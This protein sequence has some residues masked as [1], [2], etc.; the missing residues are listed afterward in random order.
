MVSKI[1]NGEVERA[2]S[3]T[4]DQ[5]IQQYEAYVSGEYVPSPNS[6]IMEQSRASSVGPRP[7][8]QIE[9]LY[10]NTA[11]L[12][13][14][15]HTDKIKVQISVVS[16]PH[17]YKRIQ[18]NG[19]ITPY[20]VDSFVKESMTYT[21]SN[22]LQN[23]FTSGS[24]VEFKVSSKEYV[25][26]GNHEDL[27]AI[28]ELSN[29]DIAA[30]LALEE[31]NYYLGTLFKT[32]ESVS[33]FCE[34]VPSIFDKFD[35]FA[36]VFNGFKSMVGYVS[37]KISNFKNKIAGQSF[38]QLVSV[39]QNYVQKIFTE[40][41]ERLKRFKLD[42]L[43]SAKTIRP[44]IANHFTKLKDDVESFFTEENMDSIKGTI[45]AQIQYVLDFFK[46]PDIEEI[47][48]IIYRFCSLLTT[49]KNLFNMKIEPL[50][51]AVQA[52]DETNLA[53]QTAS[54]K[55]TAGALRAGAIR[56]EPQ[57]Y[58]TVK[59]EQ[60]NYV[61]SRS[62][63]K[64]GNYN[65]QLIEITPMDDEGVT[66]WNNGKGDSRIG[67]NGQWVSKLGV[68]GW[69]GVKP[70]VRRMIMQVQ[71]AFGKRLI[72]NSGYRP[73]WYNDTIANSAKNSLHISGIALD[74]RWEGFNQSTAHGEFKNICKQVG[75]TG[76][77]K[78]GK[79]NSFIH[80]D[81]GNREFS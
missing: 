5:L 40:Q 65:P 61:K 6:N 4:A 25:E 37:E 8:S 34:M 55:A 1:L 33:S 19:F 39:V 17:V 70:Q 69:H 62:H 30:K 20:E 80:I 31:F 3:N 49:L 50:K 10:E 18:K 58:D 42:V 81:L 59:T 41:M 44:R 73:R 78:R 36:H 35:R 75:F 23:V 60:Y 66:P 72:I 43:S 57:Q 76:F 51:K 15:I 7:S 29:D 22:F 9:L 68:E 12:N 71:A 48:Y 67:F 38:N 11:I 56:F 47:Q 54:N 79:Y 16:Y 13:K 53:L 77:S 27:T 64:S 26:Q 14:F 28:L 46:D 32:D 21:H 74:V 2:V 24:L 45:T 52:F 63:E